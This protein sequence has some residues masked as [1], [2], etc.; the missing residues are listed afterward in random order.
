MA[1][2]CK[3]NFVQISWRC[4]SRCMPGGRVCSVGISVWECLWIYKSIRNF[5]ALVRAFTTFTLLLLLLPTDTFNDINFAC[6]WANLI[7]YS[8]CCA[9][10]SII[11]GSFLCSSKK[12]TNAR[13][14]VAQSCEGKSSTKQSLIKVSSSVSSRSRISSISL[15]FDPINIFAE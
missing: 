6:Y 14:N 15:F 2:V 4:S 13:L 9:I 12:L 3:V 5:V 11:V 10:I 8:N 1:V 7:V